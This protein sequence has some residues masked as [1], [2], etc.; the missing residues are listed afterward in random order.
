MLYVPSGPEFDWHVS[1]VSSTRPAANMGT[2]VS[3]GNNT[4][5][6]W[7]ECIGGGPMTREGYMLSLY[8]N[9]LSAASISRDA[10][11]DVG[12][13]PAGGTNYSVLIPDLLVSNAA[14]ATFSPR[15]VHYRFPIRI[16]AGSSIACRMSVNNASMGSARVVMKVQ[17]SPRD[18]RLLKYGTHVTAYGVTA[19]SS[20]GTAVTPGTTSDGT[21]TSLG[22]ISRDE[23]Y[24]QV[25]F[26]CSTTPLVTG[27]YHIDLAI[28]DGTNKIIVVE[29]LPALMG[30]GNNDMAKLPQ[31]DGFYKALAGQTIYCRMQCSGTP[32]ANISAA[33]Y[34]LGG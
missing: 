30:S 18:R 32:V 8:V 9:T 20:N 15:G 2:S 28:G 19:A 3:P 27:L 17:G 16:P 11:M 23:W 22:T 5:G 33:A 13:D 14:T 26:G 6:S 12:I 34:G 7:A 29:D 24:W 31:D 21:W 25:G 4:K 1:N 10:I